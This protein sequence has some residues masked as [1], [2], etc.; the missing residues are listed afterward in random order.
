MDTATSCWKHLATY[1]YKERKGL[2][3]EFALGEGLVGQCALE[4]ERTL[5]TDVPSDYVQLSCGLG[6][7][8]PLIVIVLPVLLE[9]E[10]KAVIEL[11]SFHPF[12]STSQAFLEQL[13]ESISIVLN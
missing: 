9:G 8:T 10:V 3:T 12:R 13:T 1:A 5:L 2:S 7:A 6:H 4:K 11:A